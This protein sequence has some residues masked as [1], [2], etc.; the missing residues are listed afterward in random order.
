MKNHSFNPVSAI[1]EA[2]TAE[3]DRLAIG[4]FYDLLYTGV[5]SIWTS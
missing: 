2:I 5:D 3:T 4:A 1:Q